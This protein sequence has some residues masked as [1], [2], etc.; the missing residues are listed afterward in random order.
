MGILGAKSEA[1]Y[2]KHPKLPTK[3]GL[4]RRKRRFLRRIERPERLS[5][6]V[7]PSVVHGIS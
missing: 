4:F 3:T 1:P 7:M 2:W 6:V 5:P